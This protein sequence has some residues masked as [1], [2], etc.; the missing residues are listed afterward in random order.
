M[1]SGAIK[2]FKSG[3]ERSTSEMLRSAQVY[4]NFLYLKTS[5]LKISNISAILI[6]VRYFRECS[7]LSESG[8]RIWAPN[9]APNRAPPESGTRNF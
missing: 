8:A 3:P 5:N 6:V 4:K 2:I 7:A 1:W 9:M